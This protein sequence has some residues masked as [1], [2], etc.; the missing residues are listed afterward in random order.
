MQK[1]KGITII[2]LV[3]TIVLMLIL[4]AT[5]ITA[6]V[7]G[8]L[9]EYAGKAVNSNNEKEIIEN[10][11]TAVALVKEERIGELEPLKIIY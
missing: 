9:F 8:N 11:Q 10:I 4:A 6:L 5:T 7:D 1:N 3:I 2:V